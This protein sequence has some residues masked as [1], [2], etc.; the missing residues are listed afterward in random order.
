MVGYGPGHE[1]LDQYNQK[2]GTTN[3]VFLGSGAGVLGLG[4]DDNT[5]DVYCTTGSYG[6]DLRAY[7]SALTLLQ[8][9]GRI[10]NDPT[11]LAIPTSEISFNP[12]NLAKT[13]SPD[14][15][16]AEATLTIRSLLTIQ[17]TSTR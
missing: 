7:N 10:G 5:S 9:V 16:A 4:V 15:V 1:F 2:T 3:R 6:D 8:N 14:P 17:I 12:L 13:D 11:G